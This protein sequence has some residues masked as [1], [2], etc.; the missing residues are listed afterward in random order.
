MK[1]A[2]RLEIKKRFKK[3][4]TISRIAGCYVDCNKTKVLRFNENFLNLPEEEF[5]KY[6]EIA[7]KSFS[8]TI[9]NN[10]IELPFP[11]AE[12]Q[13][14]KQ[15]FLRGLKESKLQNEELNDMLY[16][17]IIE[18]YQYTGNY[19]ILIYHDSYDVMTKTTDNIK[20]DESEEV[21]EYI[22]VSICPVELTKAGLG[23][24][25]DLNKI[26]ARIRDWVVGTPDLAFMFPAF[27]D[28]SADIH[29]V[30]YYIKEP[31]APHAEFIRDVLGCEQK[32]TA[33]QHRDVL[34]S[35][36]K[37]AYGSDRDKAEDVLMEIQESISGMVEAREQEE[38]KLAAPIELDE[39]AFNE[40]FEDVNIREEKALEIKKA[41][42][43]EFA[44]DMPKVD[45]LL[46]AKAVKANAP[47]KREKELLREVHELKGRLE[48]TNARLRSMGIPVT[49]DAEGITDGQVTAHDTNEEISASVKEN[50]AAGELELENIPDD[51]VYYGDDEVDGG[52]LDVMV[53]VNCDRADEIKTCTINSRRCIVI[54]IDDNDEIGVVIRE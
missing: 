19:I 32:R 10:I 46:D 2:D 15:Q 33:V 26:G 30:D 13:G 1:N 16:D 28:R 27:D 36:V 50:G 43:E 37:Q 45:D 20:L 17:M 23:Y 39:N 11:A 44:G 18:H 6:L 47:V 22:L 53:H 29:K 34:K 5:Y 31:K 21:F 12:E 4:C 48:N 3:D 14:G 54:P 42:R 51:A 35:V 25:A 49:D 9:G 40:I 7:K 8:G 52:M 41:C 24:R 38:G